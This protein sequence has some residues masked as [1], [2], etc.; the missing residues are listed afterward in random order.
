MSNSPRF[1]HAT[2]L[3]R[4]ADRPGGTQHDMMHRWSAASLPVGFFNRPSGVL[5]GGNH[6]RRAAH[7]HVLR[8]FI[9]RRRFCGAK[10]ATQAT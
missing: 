6:R 7:P 9:A 1:S 5:F 3:R 4:E 10:E 8:G 2:Y